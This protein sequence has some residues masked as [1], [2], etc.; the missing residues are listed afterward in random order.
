VDRVVCVPWQGDPGAPHTAISGEAVTLYAVIYGDATGGTFAYS[1]DF[2]D[3]SPSATGT[4]SVPAGGIY[5]LA[6]SHTFSGAVGASF[7]TELTVGGSSDAYGVMIAPDNSDS[8]V[9]IAIDRGLWYLHRQMIRTNGGSPVVPMG[10]W[11]D[12]G[13]YVGRTGASVWAFEVQGHLLAVE[14]DP[15]NPVEDPYV[16]DVQRG[17]NYLLTRTYPQAMNAQTHGHPEDY[18]GDGTGDGNGIGLVTYYQSNH[19]NYESGLAMG[20]IA[21]SGSPDAVAATGNV[22]YVLGRTY[23]EIVQDM[24]DW[25]AWSQ[26]DSS[27]HPTGGARGGWY[28]WASNNANWPSSYG[29]NSACQWAYIGI[30]AAEA[31]FG[32]DVAPFVKDELAGYLHSQILYRGDC[33]SYRASDSNSAG[34]DNVCLTGGALVGIALVG[35]A[36]Y[37]AKNGAGAYAADVGNIKTFLGN[38]WQGTAWRYTENWYGHRAYYTMYAVMKGLRLHGIESLP[39]SPGTA[40]WYADYYGVMIPDQRSDGYWRGTGW[41]DSYIREDMGTAFGV[42]I[43]TPSVFSPPPVACFDAEPN[44]GYVD[45]PIA[46]DPTCTYHSDGAKEIVLYE[47]DWDNDG[48]FDQSTTTPEIVTHTW[49]SA[50]FP[51]AVYPV[52][53]R[54]TDDSDPVPVTDTYVLDINLTTPPH[55]PV[56][57]AGGPYMVSLC[58][59][60]ALALDGT[61]SWDI[62][63]GGSQDGTAPFD[64]IQAWLWDVGGAP[65]DYGDLSGETGAVDP[66]AYFGAG[67]FAI[68]LKVTDNTAAAY[69]QSGE[70]DLSDED[71]STVTVYEGCICDLSARV[72]RGKVQLTWTDTGAD[73]YD[74]YRSTRGSSNGFVLIADDVV[75]T[76]ATFLDANVENGTTYYYRVVTSDGCG[77]VSAAATPQA[78]RR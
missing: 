38:N 39:G 37:D 58:P 5:N 75:T 11:N 73:S 35:E 54:V 24:V 9:N 67:T 32:C 57:D 42:L 48:V 53:L 66:A 76:Y 78:S 8:R 6:V 17:I 1:W 62:D 20:A 52:T 68:G 71:F 23:R 29:D 50:S 16:E 31:N 14:A 10:Y 49:D 56:A 44:P 27:A 19:T 43:L 59:G 12:S 45:I 69:P 77:S 2:R 18:D 30:E 34:Y 46:F 61:G 36:R 26:I 41:M 65:W 13:Y 28:Y 60:D 25:Y 22:A 70:G 63:T 64:G 4:V 15:L 55:P 40:N 74:I 72:K 21:G 3:G 7:P 47:W 33:V 51:L